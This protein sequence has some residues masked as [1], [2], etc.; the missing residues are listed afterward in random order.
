M[1]SKIVFAFGAAA[2]AD[3]D[4][5]LSAKLIHLNAALDCNWKSGQHAEI[6]SW[7]CGYACDNAGPVTDVELLDFKLLSSFGIVA[8]YGGQCLVSFR[9]TKDLINDIE[10]GDIL[11]AKPYPECPDCKVHGGFHGNWKVLA[12]ATRKALAALDCAPGSS[13]PVL[14]TGHSLGAAM[15]ALAL[16]DLV[17]EGYNVK[18]AYT[19]GQPRVG[20]A[21][22]AK[23][24]DA[25]M[26]GVSYYRVTNFKDAVPAV[27]TK[28]MGYRHVGPEVYYH[29]TQL[30]AYKVC[31]GDEDPTC[32]DNW[33][34]ITVLQ[35]T[36]D[37]CS[38]LGLNP[39]HCSSVAP[40]CT[41]PRAEADDPN[42]VV[43]PGLLP[44]SNASVVV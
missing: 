41:E 36:C 17:G 21:N 15:A 27:P 18:T 10:D 35:H 31:D 2:S 43:P 20:D 4:E 9:G 38:Y 19:Y 5:G 39:C 28:W 29:A 23:E 32:N 24:F 25:R 3:Y 34:L 16:F 33:N 8:N 42:F 44:P 11:F 12:G 1:R 7:S 6:K 14:I 30:G 40:D 22:F 13:K 37:H 26:A